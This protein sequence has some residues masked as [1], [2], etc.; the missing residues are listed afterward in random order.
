MKSDLYALADS[1]YMHSFE[2]DRTIKGQKTKS[3]AFFRTVSD[4][5]RHY[6]TLFPC[7]SM[8][9]YSTNVNV[10]RSSLQGSHFFFST[11]RKLNSVSKVACAAS[12]I[13][14]SGNIV[15]PTLSCDKITYVLTP[16][17]KKI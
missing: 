15:V 2:T 5:P 12:Y 8:L 3:F 17:G 14:Y 16:E 6:K 13:R 11:I 9:V 1:L 4:K 7:Y 10:L